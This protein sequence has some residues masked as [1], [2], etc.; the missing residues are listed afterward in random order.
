[1]QL[2][3]PARGQA[4]VAPARE[5]QRRGATCG[6]AQLQGPVEGARAPALLLDPVPA[7]ENLVVRVVRP[8]ADP[9][10]VVEEARQQLAASSS[11]R[12][13]RGRGGDGRNGSAEAEGESSSGSVAESMAQDQQDIPPILEVTPVLFQAEDAPAP[14]D[15]MS[16]PLPRRRRSSAGPAPVQEATAPAVA[17]AAVSG[18]TEAE[19]ESDLSAEPRRRRRRSSAA[20]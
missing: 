7:V 16:V 8:D 5:D 9:E 11:R 19:A 12:R 20:G 1:M 18:G 13:R 14:A 17:V 2:T 15:V 6:R 4:P 3:S 10:A